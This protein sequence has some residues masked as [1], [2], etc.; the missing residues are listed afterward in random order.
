M[1]TSR[2]PARE[3]LNSPLFKRILC[4]L[5]VEQPTPSVLGLAGLI[6]ERF[7]ASLEALYV[8]P[9]AGFVSGIAEQSFDKIVDHLGGAPSVS[10][11]LASG[12]PAQAILERATARGVDL[13]VLGSRERS[14]LGWQFRD[15][16]VRDVSAMADCATL[17]VH[18]RDQ[19]AS[20]DRILVPVDFGPATTSMV[21]WTSAFA[22]RFGAKVQLLHVVSRERLS[23]RS[24]SQRS[25]FCVVPGDAMA[26]LAVLE[27]RLSARGVDVASQMVLGGCVANGIES[28][29]EQGEYDLVVMGGG[30][31]HH[32]ASRL[33]RGVIASLRNRLPV[34]ML[35]VRATSF[36]AS[37]PRARAIHVRRDADRRASVGL[38]A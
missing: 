3:R 23:D 1:N 38:S 18:E 16:V 12:S 6:A 35:S 4:A 21:E 13:I 20:I 10:V 22:L 25:R 7:A 30:D 11:S 33:T 29:N 17:T 32:G 26:E 14:D 5:D 34:P 9:A 31:A 8:R 24:A 2:S 28:Y 15:D 19:P 27:Q 36:D 37:R